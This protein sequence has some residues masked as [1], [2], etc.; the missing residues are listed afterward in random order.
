MNELEFITDINI[1]SLKEGDILIIKT[2]NSLTDDMMDK[3]CSVVKELIPDRLKD[4]VSIVLTTDC[5]VLNKSF[6][7]IVHGII[8]DDFCHA[9]PIR[10]TL[11]KQIRTEINSFSKK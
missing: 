5:E 11:M 4:K 10:Q 9:G 6:A 1:M 3:L 8:N 2:F 7:N